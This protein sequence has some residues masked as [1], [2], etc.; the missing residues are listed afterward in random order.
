M[1][2]AARTISAESADPIRDLDRDQGHGP[3]GL[4]R[5]L[6]FGPVELE[7]NLLL[8]PIA[9]YCDLAFRLTCRAFN[10]DPY[11]A[12][13]R[14]GSPAGLGLACTDLLSPH[15]LLRG[16]A[17]SLDLART[18]DEDKPVGMQLYGG[19]PG[20]MAE[21][22][23]WAADHGA[24]VV[25]INMGCPVDKVTKKDGGS[26]LMVPDEGVDPSPCRSFGLAVAIARAVREA[27]PDSVPLTAKMRLGWR[28]ADDAPKLACALADEGVV[29][30]TVHGRT[31]EQ[32][33]KGE[34]D[35]SGIQRVV[36]AVHEKSRGWSG[37]R[38]PVIGNGDIREPEDA[39]AMLHETGCDGVMI[40]RGALS[41]PWLFRDTWAL[42]R[43]GSVPPPLTDGEKIEVVRGFLARMLEFRGE[44]Y[45]MMQIRRRIT[46]FAKR[47]GEPGE[48]TK[49]F[50]EA[51]RVASKPSDV[52]AALDGWLDGRLRDLRSIRPNQNSNNASLDVPA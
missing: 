49:P 51:V 13:G 27:L 18:T 31:T 33:F 16:T 19:E 52:H 20:I 1:I 2:D 45:A 47:L 10:Q 11:A 17:T 41:T 46:W 3:E 4:A 50:R 44:R 5:P 21:G 22:A 48:T 38:I 23:R 34:A 24:T 26:R 42:L 25:D 39:R 37:G 15:G 32:K 8:A 43:T 12:P 30:I 40:G 7:T 29:G 35:R 36:E 28:C 6:R 9:G 14:S